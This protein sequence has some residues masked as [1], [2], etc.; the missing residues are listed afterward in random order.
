MSRIFVN[1]KK[2]YSLQ[3]DCDTTF[4]FRMKNVLKY[5]Y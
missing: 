1:I 4:K 5:N 2:T 3:Y